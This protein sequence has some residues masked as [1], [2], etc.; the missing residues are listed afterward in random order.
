[1]EGNEEGVDFAQPDKRKVNK[2]LSED[3]MSNKNVKI[4]SI[5]KSNTEESDE[6]MFQGFKEGGGDTTPPPD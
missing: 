4:R 3:Q 1:M 2:R 5:E 6:N